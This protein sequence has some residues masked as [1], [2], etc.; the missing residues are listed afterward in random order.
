MSNKNDFDEFSEFR[1]DNDNEDDV[2]KFLEERRKRRKL[3]IDKLDQ[4]DEDKDD[5]EDENEVKEEV[6]TTTTTIDD[7]DVG[8]TTIATKTDNYDMFADSPPHLPIPKGSKENGS[9]IN[10][11]TSILES[12]SNLNLTSNWDDSEGYYMAKPGEIIDNNYK[13]LGSFG[14]GVFA[15]VL[16][17]ENINDNNQIVAAK[18]VRNNDLMRKAAQQEMLI[19]RKLKSSTKNA[20]IHC[21]SLVNHLYYRNHTIM[22]FEGMHCNLRDIIKKYGSGVGIN[23]HVIQIYAFQLIAGLNFLSELNIVHADL[24]PD[25]ILVSADLKQLKISDFGSAYLL[26]DPAAVQPTPY[27][28]SRFYRA[29]EIILGLNIDQRIDMWSL[30]TSLAELATGIVL[31]NGNNNNEILKNMMEYKGNLPSKLIKSHIRA[32]QKL[33]ME[34]HFTEETLEF[35]FIHID[36]VSQTPVIRLIKSFD[37]TCSNNNNKIRNKNKTITSF[38]QNACFDDDNGGDDDNTI[39]NQ[40]ADLLERMLILDVQKRPTFTDIVNHPY[41]KKFIKK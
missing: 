12:D 20:R 35:K 33:E 30:A 19:L 10:T 14:K 9:K 34:P 15:T 8:T 1:D 29:P 21:I 28:V 16:K 17:C 27:L 2:A 3:I 26:S 22:I 36:P 5:D 18:I 4:K 13:V 39:V 31:F 11:T 41:L 25:N 32:Y 24:K 37:T 6:N 38:I 7:N 23:N 40:L